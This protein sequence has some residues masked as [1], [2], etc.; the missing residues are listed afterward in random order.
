MAAEALA[1]LKQH[2]KRVPQDVAIAGFQNDPQYYHLGISTCGPDWDNMG[3]V[4]AHAIIGDMRL[5]RSGRGF[6]KARCR[7]M[8]K[9]TTPR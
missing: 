7:M 2:G 1:W 9:L 5:A 6:L 8:E 3:Y 4:M